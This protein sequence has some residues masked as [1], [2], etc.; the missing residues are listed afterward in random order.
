MQSSDSGPSAHC[1]G[2][3][4]IPGPVPHHLQTVLIFVLRV[5]HSPASALAAL[6]DLKA[7][8]GLMCT[9]LV[10]RP[11][12]LLKTFGPPRGHCPGPGPTL[13]RTVPN[14]LAGSRTAPLVVHQPSPY[15]RTARTFFL[16]S[17]SGIFNCSTSPSTNNQTSSSTV[18]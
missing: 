17:S 10:P 1:R 18:I 12:N 8:S 5:V 2:R 16:C 14:F 4:E 11:G 9:A 6:W 13:A 7:D 3:N 15:A